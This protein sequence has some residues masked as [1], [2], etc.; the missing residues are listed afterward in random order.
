LARS[1]IKKPFYTTPNNI[2]RGEAGDILGR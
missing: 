2:L 1:A